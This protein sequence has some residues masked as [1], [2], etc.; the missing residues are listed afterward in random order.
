[1]PGAAAISFVEASVW[2]AADL[3]STPPPPPPQAVIVRTAVAS[4]PKI[5]IT[6]LIPSPLP[7]MPS[8]GGEHGRHD[9]QRDAQPDEGSVDSH[10]PRI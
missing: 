8:D 7:L 6:R 5:P 2:G 9:Q 3:S 10:G 4:R 1:V